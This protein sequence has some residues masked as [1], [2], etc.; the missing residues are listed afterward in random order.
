MGKYLYLLL[1]N[2]CMPLTT[3][4]LGI[5]FEPNNPNSDG[6]GMHRIIMESVVGF[7]GSNLDKEISGK[8]LR[9]F[10]SKYA[11][12]DT[13]LTYIPPVGSARLVEPANLGDLGIKDDELYKFMIEPCPI[14]YCS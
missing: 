10:I 2:V 1:Q 7:P 4:G 5:Y 11:P 12:E 13:H 8:Q 14:N 6:A 3:M 9:E